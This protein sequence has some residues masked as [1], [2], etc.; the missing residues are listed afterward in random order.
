MIRI[1][2]SETIILK[3]LL[4]PSICGDSGAASSPDEGACGDELSHELPLIPVSSHD[5]CVRCCSA[6]KVT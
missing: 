6:G 4:R 2:L 3:N 1:F 5:Y